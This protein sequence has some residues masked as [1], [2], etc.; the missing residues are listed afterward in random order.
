MIECLDLFISDIGNIYSTL[1]ITS[2]AYIST[3]AP[4]S[5][6]IYG[7]ATLTIDGHGFSNNISQIQ[8]TIGSNSCPVVQATES[9]IQCTVPPQGNSPSLANISISS[10]QVSFPSAFVLNYSHA[11]TPNITSV[12]PNFG[13]GS[14]NLVITGNNLVSS[15][16]TNVKIGDTPCNISNRLITSITCTVGLDLPAGN[17]SVNVH[18]DDIGDSNEDIFYMQDLIIANVTPAEGGYGGGLSSTVLGNGFNGSGVSVRVCN[19]SCL[20][21]QIVSNDE[22]ICE[23]PPATMTSANTWCNMTV[24]VDGIQKETVFS[25]ESNL[26]AMITSVSPNRGGTGG[27][28]TIVINGTNFP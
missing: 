19:K 11:I 25:Y 14:Q 22:L 9:R 5:S 13:S 24:N 21:V 28:T 20:S 17:H 12:S 18:V 1:N 4:L 27:G 10:H 16:Q 7:G 2:D 3:V 15:G 23:T 8:V 6:S 26:T